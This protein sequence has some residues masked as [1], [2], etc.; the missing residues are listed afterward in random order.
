MD[1]G[2]TVLRISFLNFALLYLVALFNVHCL[3][4]ESLGYMTNF[5]TTYILR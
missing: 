1:F 3:R 5:F 4:D 2:K